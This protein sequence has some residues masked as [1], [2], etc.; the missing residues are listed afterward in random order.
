MRTF[1]EEIFHESKTH[2]LSPEPSEKK[3]FPPIPKPSDSQEEEL[4]LQMS[5]ESTT[6]EEEESPLQ[7]NLKEEIK[8]YVSPIREPSTVEEDESTCL[9][10]LKRKISCLEKLNKLKSTRI[11]SL[12]KINWR[13]KK[14][15]SFLKAM[16]VQMKNRNLLLDEHSNVYIKL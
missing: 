15:I 16:M 3:D 12:Q 10:S 7:R 5:T 9:R 8:K 11:R 2:D 6:L 4:S 1:N 13:Q 14:Q